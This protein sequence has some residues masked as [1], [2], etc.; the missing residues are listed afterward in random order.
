MTRF[1]SETK[2]LTWTH[3]NTIHSAA[4]ATLRGKEASYDT[5]WLTLSHSQRFVAGVNVPNDELV[6]GDL[7]GASRCFAP[8]SPGDLSPPDR[9]DVQRAVHAG[10]LSVLH[11]QSAASDVYINSVRVRNFAGRP[12]PND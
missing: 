6:E 10:Y 4:A 8:A 3:L 5:L 12:G 1:A 7:P 2:R 9:L 11:T